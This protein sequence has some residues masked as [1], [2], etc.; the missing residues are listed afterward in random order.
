MTDYR[1]NDR[2]TRGD[3]ANELRRSL[4]LL[5]VVTAGGVVLILFTLLLRFLIGGIP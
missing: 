1:D 3:F 4:T 2:Y 5:A